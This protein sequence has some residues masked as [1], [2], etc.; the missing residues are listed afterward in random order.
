MGGGEIDPRAFGG[1]ERD[2]KH[3]S[4]RIQRLDERIEE[5]EGAIEN[6]TALLNKA[7]GA[8]WVMVILIAAPS[9]VAGIATAL[10]VWR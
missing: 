5:L 9:F 2:V 8:W 10:K 3:L 1:L 4:D 7:R 6:L